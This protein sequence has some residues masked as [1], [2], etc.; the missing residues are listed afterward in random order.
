MG[1]IGIAETLD[2]FYIDFHAREDID[3]RL[4]KIC[5]KKIQNH[6][7]LYSCITR[8]ILKMIPEHFNGTILIS[9][10]NEFNKIPCFILIIDIFDD[11]I[12]SDLISTIELLVLSKQ[13]II[14]KKSSLLKHFES[15]SFFQ[16][17]NADLL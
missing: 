11:L 7:N 1:L 14:I 17:R 5:K 8:V 9:F 4:N 6:L 10:L 12:T 2:Q 16:K 15:I 3:Q 13:D